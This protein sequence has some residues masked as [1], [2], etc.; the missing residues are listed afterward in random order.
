L[1]TALGFYSGPIDGI[2]GPRTAAALREAQKALKRD[3]EG[4]FGNA[5]AIAGR[6]C[7]K[8]GAAAANGEDNGMNGMAYALDTRSPLWQM[9][10]LVATLPH[11]CP[12]PS[13]TTKA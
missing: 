8:S 1:L 5:S 13:G 11:H 4:V 7:Q 2:P 6:S 3:W 12:L 9:R 10:S